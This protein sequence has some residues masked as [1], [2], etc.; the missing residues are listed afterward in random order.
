MEIHEGYLYVVLNFTDFRVYNVSDP[1]RLI[2]IFSYPINGTARYFNFYQE[3]CILL[4]HGHVYFFNISDSENIG[5]T[6]LLDNLPI[7]PYV[8]H[9]YENF[10]YISDTWYNYCSYN[11]SDMTNIR[12]ITEESMKT[13]NIAKDQVAFYIFED[14]L[15]SFTFHDGEMFLRDKIFHLGDGYVDETF[16]VRDIEDNYLYLINSQI[17]LTIVDFSDPNDLWVRMRGD[18][19]RSASIKEMAIQNQILYGISRTKIHIYNVSDITIILEYDHDF[20]TRFYGI[21]YYQGFLF[22]SGSFFESTEDDLYGLGIIAPTFEDADGDSIHDI[23]EEYMY[24]TDPTCNDTDVDGL[25]DPLEIFNYTT[26][27]LTNDTDADNISDFLEIHTYN[28]NPSNNDTDGDGLSDGQEIWELPT[29]PHVT[30]TDED[31]LND[32]QEI[33]LGTDPLVVDS[34]GDEML[35]GWEVRFDLNPLNDDGGM[36]LDH[37]NLT[38]REE[39]GYQT[40]PNCTDTDNDRLSDYMEVEYFGTDPT[41]ADTDGD[42]YSDAQE[43]AAGSDPNNREETPGNLLTSSVSTNSST[44]S[45]PM[46]FNVPGFPV[47]VLVGNIGIVISIL[48][49]KR[50]KQHLE[51]SKRR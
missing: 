26:N 36:D 17:G 11:I 51:I 27:P 48:I 31:G 7:K 49:G 21:L 3:L 50:R 9:I 30:D 42:S 18:E 6:Q 12:F 39:Y 10:L 32:G 25:S 38:N 46:N 34:D 33:Q 5:C 44:T 47:G 35:D 2:Q 20:G 45:P 13:F 40:Y 1:C 24:G 28:T 23:T 37:D 43:V 14:E 15:H 16:Y 41:K 22:I 8:S 4:S 19:H 29:D